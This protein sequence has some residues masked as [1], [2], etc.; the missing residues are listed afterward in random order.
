MKIPKFKKL[1]I[2]GGGIKGLVI[3]GTLEWIENNTKILDNIEEIYGSSIGAYI[4]FFL[5]LGISLHNI[6]L[7]FEN[8]NLANLQ[9]F[10]MNLFIN[11]YGF[12]K[13]NKFMNLVR[14]TIKT[15]G[16]NP[17]I[18]FSEFQK[19]S[20]YKLFICG[21]NINKAEAV[22]F[23]V[24]THKDMEI[25]L[26]LRISGGYPFSFTP[27]N[28]NGDLYADG[29][30]MCPLPCDLINKKDKK[31]TL[32]IVNHRSISRYE[33]DSFNKYLMSVISCMIDSL[34]DKYVQSLKYVIK[35]KYP[36]FSMNFNIEKEEKSKMIEYGKNMAKEW[37]SK[38]SFSLKD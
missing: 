23:S 32:A 30:I 10:D 31:I 3:C 18:T 5:G 11:E 17:N 9:D 28:I 8:F 24:D 26:A 16:Y 27:I 37:F 20:K 14:A 33:T 36:I 35:L 19:I 38:F 21:T 7:I 1:V 6:S 25:C 4:G 22:Y 2:S 29:A 12:D 13:G 34:T 15:Q